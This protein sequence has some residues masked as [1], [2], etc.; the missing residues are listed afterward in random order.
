MKPIRLGRIARLAPIPAAALLVGG[1]VAASTPPGRTAVDSA[2]VDSAPVHPAAVDSAPVDSTPVDSAPVA[3]GSVASL[4]EGYVW[5]VDDLT[6]ITVAVPADWS[7][8]DTVPAEVDGTPQPWIAAAP[9]SIQSFLATFDEPGVLVTALPFDPDP[10]F[11][12]EQYSISEGCAEF[13]VAPY[14]ERGLSGMTQIGT[15]CGADGT[16]SWQLIIANPPDASFTALV[17]VQAASGADTEAAQVALDTFT[18]LDD[19]GMAP[20]SSVPGSS[21]PGSSGPGSVPPS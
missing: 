21:V 2:P 18:M 4:P 17:Q 20:G 14:E 7:D 3:S 16:G 5:L 8:I 6:S 12:L 11:V 10:A 1:S 19:E 13:S 9:S 15:E